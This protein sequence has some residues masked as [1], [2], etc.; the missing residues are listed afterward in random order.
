MLKMH[1]ETPDED[2]STINPVDTAQYFIEIESETL[3]T[4]AVSPESNQLPEIASNIETNYATNIETNL[5]TNLGTYLEPKTN[6][7]QANKKTAESH[8]LMCGIC[9]N[10][11]KSKSGLNEHIRRKHGK[12]CL[13]LSPKVEEIQPTTIGPQK[14][15]VKK[16]SDEI[17]LK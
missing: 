12:N 1:P 2:K 4:V 14:G 6:E 5:E 7:K 10:R 15:T 11:Y 16:R 13:R 9:D 8:P 3:P 17:L